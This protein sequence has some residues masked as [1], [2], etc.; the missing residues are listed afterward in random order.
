MSDDLK[1]KYISRRSYGGCR[2]WCVRFI[3][4]RWKGNKGS[5][6]FSDREYDN[7][8][9]ASLKAAIIFRN[10]R[11]EAL[12][13]TDALINC[14]G[15]R[16]TSRKTSKNNKSGV[17]GLYRQIREVRDKRYNSKPYTYKTWTAIGVDSDGETWRSAYSIKKHGEQGA[18][19]LACAERHH[20]HGVLNLLVPVDMLP[21]D[22]GV[23]TIFIGEDN[24]KK[25][26]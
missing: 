21:C 13:E 20:R 18:F 11:L 26:S 16:T 15:Q 19:K 2:G 25:K 8:K 23:P 24:A 7:D 3:S 5:W 1:I 14:P 12:G 9:E 4:D 22:P 17:V 10:K 6:Y